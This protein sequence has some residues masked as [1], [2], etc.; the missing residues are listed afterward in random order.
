M[1]A[2]ADVGQ[3]SSI[4]QFTPPVRE[5]WLGHWVIKPGQCKETALNAEYWTWHGVVVIKPQTVVTWPVQNPQMTKETKFQH[6]WE[7]VQEVQPL[8]E[9]DWQLMGLWSL[10]NCS[11]YSGWPHLYTHRHCYPGSK[12]YFKK[13]SVWEWA[14]LYVYTCRLFRRSWREDEEVYLIKIYY[15]H[16]WNSQK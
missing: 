3:L 1:S 5:H 2:Q 12:G 14:M 13:K 4:L 11:W 9:D 16:A 15:M 6:E 10:W 7:G 8:S